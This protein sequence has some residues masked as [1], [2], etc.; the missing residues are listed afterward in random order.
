[1]ATLTKQS[2]EKI[3]TSTI[4]V[5]EENLNEVIRV[6]INSIS[7]TDFEW[8]NPINDNTFYKIVNTNVLTPELKSQALKFYRT[9]DYDK[10]CSLGLTFNAEPEVAKNLLSCIFANAIFAKAKNRLGEDIIVIKSLVPIEA[11]KVANSVFNFET[12]AEEVP[13]EVNEEILTQETA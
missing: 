3:L 10:A 1:M 12:I 7:K 11:K 6:K 8:K 13:F 9:G 5:T 4:T 2:A